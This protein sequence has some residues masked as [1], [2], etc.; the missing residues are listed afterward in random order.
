MAPLTSSDL[1]EQKRAL[2][3]EMSAARAA[4]SEGERQRCS[5]TLL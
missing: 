5:V 4:L 3:R 2:R 1:P